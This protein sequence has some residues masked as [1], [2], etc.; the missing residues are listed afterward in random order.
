VF[1]YHA[2][3]WR[4]LLSLLFVTFGLQF[5]I[6][7]INPLVRTLFELRRLILRSGFFF[8]SPPPQ[9]FYLIS[10]LLKPGDVHSKIFGVS[11]RGFSGLLIPQ[12]F[13]PR[14]RSSPS[15]SLPISSLPILLF[16]SVL[17]K[18]LLPPFPTSFPLFGEE[19]ERFTSSVFVPFYLHNSDPSPL[20]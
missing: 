3:S 8:L 16:P 20:F 19:S 15:I 1:P 12:L 2:E 11:R 7:R 13:F 14:V 9:F 17:V 6:P 18:S 5:F 10:R 4:S